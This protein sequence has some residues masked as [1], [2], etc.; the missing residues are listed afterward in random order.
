MPHEAWR[1]G[2]PDLDIGVIGLVGEAGRAQLQAGDG[3]TELRGLA[4]TPR[5]D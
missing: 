5:S 1:R 4:A 3:A 2:R